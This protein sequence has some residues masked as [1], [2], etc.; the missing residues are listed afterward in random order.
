[1]ITSLTSE[2]FVVFSTRNTVVD[3]LNKVL[4]EKLSGITLSNPLALLTLVNDNALRRRISYDG[5]FCFGA[6]RATCPF[7]N[8][9]GSTAVLHQTGGS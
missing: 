7:K 1:M 8:A 2:F 4:V 9:I 5:D 6:S 3:D